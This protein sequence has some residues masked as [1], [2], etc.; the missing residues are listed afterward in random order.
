M[1]TL[2]PSGKNVAQRLLDVDEAKMAVTYEL[3]AWPEEENANVPESVFPCTVTDYRAEIRVRPITT[4]LGS[5]FL[6]ISGRGLTNCQ[7]RSNA[8]LKDV[9]HRTLLL[10]CKQVERRSTFYT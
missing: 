8:F 3:A 1:L 7:A 4:Q 9:F 6:E 10:V 2:K 5:A